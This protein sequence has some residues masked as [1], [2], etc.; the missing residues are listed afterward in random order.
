M[1]DVVHPFAEKK[2][3]DLQELVETRRQVGAREY[4]HEVAEVVPALERHPTDGIVADE[5]G[6]D[7]EP[8]ED[9]GVDAL[10]AVA[11]KVDPLLAEEVDGVPVVDVS[12]GVEIPEIK[13]PDVTAIGTKIR[14]VAIGIRKCQSQLDDV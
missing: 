14:K 3:Q 1:L 2:P 9:G 10:G 12:L 7:H 5:S 13:L 6:L 11:V 8:R 4:L